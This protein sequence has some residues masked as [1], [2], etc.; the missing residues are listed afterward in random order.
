MAC[1]S[2][3]ISVKPVT[4]TI[5]HTSIHVVAIYIGEYV[6]NLRYQFKFNVY[7]RVKKWYV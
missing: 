1:P 2:I 5:L 4:Y 6:F 3:K 7:T